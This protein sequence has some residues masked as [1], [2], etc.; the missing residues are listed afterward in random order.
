MS[1]LELV[2]EMMR[3]GAAAVV[4]L[5]FFGLIL[6]V[7]VFIGTYFWDLFMGDY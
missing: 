1:F 3:Y 4:A 2:F 7:L 5:G 6:G